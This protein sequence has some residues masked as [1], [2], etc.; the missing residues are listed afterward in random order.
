MKLYEFG[1]AP[2]AKTDGFGR[3]ITCFRGTE[4]E[5]CIAYLNSNVALIRGAML[6]GQVD[7]FEFA[8]MEGSSKT[9]ELASAERNMTQK[10]EN[11]DK[12]Y[13]ITVDGVEFMTGE[14]ASI[15]VVFR[16]LE[17]HNFEPR[18]GHD[19]LHGEW[20]QWAAVE[21][22]TRLEP[23]TPIEMLSPEGTVL[24]KGKIKL[25]LS[26]NLCLSNEMDFGLQGLRTPRMKG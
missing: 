19:E 10:T 22:K 12:Q 3:I 23:F 24:Q 26:R 13:R 17:G 16:N 8:I 9:L 20:L 2:K 25:S 15:G 7:S 14:A 11:H 6:H 5:A 4:E 1:E 18:P 21:F